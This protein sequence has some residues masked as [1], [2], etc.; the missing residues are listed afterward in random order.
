MNIL[1]R[2]KN[3][4]TTKALRDFVDSQFSKIKRL[5]LPIQK[6]QVFLENIERKDSDPHRASVQVTAD[7]AKKGRVTVESK[8]HDLY[9]AVGEATRSL[10]RHLR[11]EKEKRVHLLRRKQRQAK[12]YD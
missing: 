4:K 8:T 10:M 2:A 7:I 5:G 12:N 6:V 3:M 9:K 1:V 11:K